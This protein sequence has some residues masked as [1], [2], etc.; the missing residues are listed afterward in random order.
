MS[1]LPKPYSPEELKEKAEAYFKELGIDPTK[2]PNKNDLPEPPS[3][4]PSALK[5]DTVGVNKEFC[6]VQVYS[7]VFYTYVVVQF[8]H[9]EFNGHS[10]GLGIGGMPLTGGILLFKDLKT[11]LDTKVFFVH[12]EAVEGGLCQV[13][14]GTHG[15][16]TVIGV[17][18]GAGAFAGRGK[19]G[20]Q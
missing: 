9:H 13:S 10:G 7:F 1:T 6:M 20:N 18:G 14:W 17:G 16:A 11:L 12:F 8:Q 4:A 5:A 3:T 19:W 15:S 2:E